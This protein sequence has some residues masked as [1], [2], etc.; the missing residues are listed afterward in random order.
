[1]RLLRCRSLALLRSTNT[2]FTAVL[3]SDAAKAAS[4]AAIVPYTTRGSTFT[5]RLFCRVLCTVAYFSPLGGRFRLAGRRP[6][7]PR[8]RG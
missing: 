8:R 7:R 5:T 3:T 2:V 1:M 4:T 6:R